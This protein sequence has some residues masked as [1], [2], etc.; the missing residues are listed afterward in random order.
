MFRALRAVDPAEVV[1]GQYAGYR[2]EKDVAPDS[3]VET[4]CALALHI[5]SWRWAGVPWFLRAGKALPTDAVEV[6]VQLKAPPQQLFDDAEHGGERPNYVRFKLQ[7]VSAVALAARIKRPGKGY[8]GEQ[9]EL[10]LCE[11]ATG[12]ESTYERLL[13]D[14]MAGDASLFTG[15]DAVE[16]AW[17][18]VQP[19]LD[20][21]PKA[22]P[23][24]KGS[25]GPDAACDLIHDHGGWHDPAPEDA[26]AGK[27]CA[28]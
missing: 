14:A 8:V 11:N 10:Y 22:I 16:A 19:V 15:Q 20:H 7:P 9:R 13:G 24:R 6:L 5:D 1:R 28:P 27:P 26:S 12:G 4:F 2:D 3:D 23:Y 17:A 25:W 18:A 21:P